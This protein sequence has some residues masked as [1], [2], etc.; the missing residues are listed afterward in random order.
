MSGVL[1]RRSL[2]SARPKWP[3]ERTKA[4]GRCPATSV[5]RCIGAR[6]RR[7]EM[8]TADAPATVAAGETISG[9]DLGNHGGGSDG[10]FDTPAPS[11]KSHRRS[12]TMSQ[13]SVPV[14]MPRPQVATRRANARTSR[15]ASWLRH[16]PSSET[17]VHSRI[18]DSRFARSSTARLAHDQTEKV[19]NFRTL[20][21]CHDMGNI[22]CDQ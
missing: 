14:A 5:R 18:G 4:D 15:D 17:A 21:L 13:S 7:N 6:R 20:V 2:E 8:G 11:S 12:V 19:F 16:D 1:G 9:S 3:S 22:A 10:A